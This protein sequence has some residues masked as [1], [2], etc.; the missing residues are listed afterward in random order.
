MSRIPSIEPTTRYY[1]ADVEAPTEFAACSVGAL[2]GLPVFKEVPGDPVL[3]GKFRYVDGGWEWIGPCPRR[4]ISADPENTGAP[5]CE[6]ECHWMQVFSGY[7]RQRNA[8]R[9]EATTLVQ[10]ERCGWNLLPGRIGGHP[11]DYA[12]CSSPALARIGGAA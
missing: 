3:G 8:L 5:V 4:P 10:P 11:L 1:V 12:P 7:D 9:I 6:P 2:M